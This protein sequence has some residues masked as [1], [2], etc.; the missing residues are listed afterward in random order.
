M[1]A[2]VTDVGAVKVPTSVNV[3]PSRVG[4]AVV[5]KLGVGA[6]E[7]PTAY[8]GMTNRPD[9]PPVVPVTGVAEKGIQNPG[10]AHVTEVP[11]VRMMTRTRTRHRFFML[12]P[13]PARFTEVP[14]RRR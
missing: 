13:V 6:G 1:R 3:A 2:G 9:F 10:L 11:S 5:I 12:A 7:E 14:L 8:D 4:S